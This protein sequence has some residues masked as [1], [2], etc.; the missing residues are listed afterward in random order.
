[1]R[2][3]LSTHHNLDSNAGAPGSMMSIA[4]A[5]RELGHEVVLRS[6]DD[7]PSM[8]SLQR[9]MVSYPWSFALF[10]RRHA[11]TFDVVDAHT[12]DAW[13]WSLLRNGRS[14]PP[15]VVHSQGIEHLAH[16]ATLRE[17]Q[18][19]HVQLSHKYPLYHGGWRL[20]EVEITLRRSEGAV[21]LNRGERDWAETRFSL[22]ASRC[23]VIHHGLPRELLGLRLPE[24]DEEN[25]IRVAQIGTYIHRKGTVWAAAA[26]DELMA[27]HPRVGA[28]FLG[29]H[30][31]RDIVLR[32]FRPE[33][34]ERVRVV[35]SFSRSKLP[36]LLRGHQIVL[37]A[38]LSEGFGM[39]L[40][41]G[42]ACGLAAV[43]TDI[44]GPSEF[45]VDGHSGLL[46]PPA[47]AEAIRTALERL[48]ADRALLHRMRENAHAT[49]QT[50]TWSENARQ[51]LAV[52][53]AVRAEHP[54]SAAAAA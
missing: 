36:A 34:H 3:L 25:T 28:T 14:S 1:M 50:Y 10:A 5:L 11:R 47:D 51:R 33:H 26:L 30:R 35:E 2:I 6:F 24:P 53:E 42:M 29:T 22:D 21:F 44:A 41:E 7:L 32:D 17:A 48:I 9:K 31:S 19:G 18:A 20:R 15:L 46:V 23:F 37:S 8:W 43:S 45:V 40:L 49:A 12:G 54:R 39:A 52:Y 16:E 27:T 4:A 13:V 38:S